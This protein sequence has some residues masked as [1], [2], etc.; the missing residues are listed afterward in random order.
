MKT[1]IKN[2]QI[3]TSDEIIGGGCCLLE[4]GLITY[5]GSEP[6]AADRVLDAKGCYLLPGFIDIHCHGGGGLE[7][8]DASVEE[9]Q[10]IADF[11]LR[12]GTTTLLATTLAADW[13]ETE[14]ALDTLAMHKATKPDSSLLGVHLEGP[15]LNPLQCGAQNT[16]YMKLP[17]ELDIAALKRKYPFILRL[18]A[19]PELEGGLQLGEAAAA[20]G[21]SVS[22]AHTDADFS[23]ME[24][25]L[26]HGYTGITHL[27]SGMKG[28]TRK[29]SFRIAGAVE[30]GLYFD[31]YTVEII[32]DGCHLP[33]DLLRLIY[34]CK[35]ADRIALVTD[36]IRAA[37][38]SEGT[39]T[40][41]GSLK[42]GLPVIVEDGVAKTPD[43]QSFA[44]SAATYDRLY[45]TM[46]EAVGGDR[47]AL[48]RMTALTPARALGLTDRGEIACGKRADL[49]LMNEE[50][51]ITHIFLGGNEI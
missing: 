50:N 25:A 17:A 23:V 29:N 39:K 44:G 34:K 19:A 36:A 30:A 21:I 20:L 26:S 28:V 42:N 14:N 27:Y 51:Q 6:Q 43:R 46:W 45:R 35:G 38:L 41:I 13:A 47:V 31:E 40:K 49:V 1:L 9:V 10:A 24:E 4:D 22:A 33:T 3:V 48:S 18:S 37:G 2:A 7:F 12:H 8:M 16:A 5:V 11:H 15:C 32:A